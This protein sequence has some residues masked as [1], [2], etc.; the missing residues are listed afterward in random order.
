MIKN[1]R[2]VIVDIEFILMKH[3]VIQQFKV[4]RI[5]KHNFLMNL[6]LHTV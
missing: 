6:N 4:V 2:H 3:I 1:V 5:L